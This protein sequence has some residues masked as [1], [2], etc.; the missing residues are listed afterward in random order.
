MVQEALKSQIYEVLKDTVESDAISGLHID[1]NQ[2]L[3]FSIT[4]DPAR[5]TALEDMRQEAEKKVIGIKGV[6]SATV[7]LTAKKSSAPAAAAKSDPHGMDKNPKLHVAAKNIIAVASGKGGVG[8]ST[9]AVNLAMAMAKG[10]KKIGLL[11]CDIYGPSVPTLT[12]LP[13]KRPK[14][15]GGKLIP[16]ETNSVKVMSIGFLTDKDAAMIW[17]GPMVQTAVYQMLRDTKWDNEVGEPLDV[18]ILDMPPGTGDAQ[19]T[20]AQKIDVTGAVIV[21]TPQDL[22]LL[23]AVKAINMF[24]KTDVPILGLIEN[25]S[26][27][28]CDNCGHESHIFGHDTVRQEAEKRGVAF[29]GA[30]PLS[31][32]LRQKSDEGILKTSEI[33]DGFA[34]EVLP[35]CHSERS[36]GIS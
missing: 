29:L 22:A 36:R 2:H 18:L 35:N 32:E 4:V 19:L 33:F 28:I 3:I 31:I 1:D 5:G 12:D 9:V 6:K 15:V 21:S 30:I 34:K 10:G 23:D 24:E 27:Y 25:M 7:V 11:D 20:I 14:Q 8:K 16:F 26:T 13:I 17:R